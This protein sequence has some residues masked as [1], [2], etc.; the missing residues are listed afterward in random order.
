MAEQETFVLG[1]G[2]IAV[3]DSTVLG[4]GGMRDP[5]SIT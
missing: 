2:G 5:G 3:Q 4:G 1:G